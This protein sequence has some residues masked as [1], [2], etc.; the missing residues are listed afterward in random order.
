MP[1]VNDILEER[2]TTYGAFKD[3]ARVAQT[4]KRVCA[5]TPNW[6]LAEPDQQEA[7]DMFCSKMSRL[8]TGDINHLDSW[9]DIA[10]Y[11]TLVADRLEGKIR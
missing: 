6:K 1:E 8:L 10:G 7:L 9:Q 4:L 2:G 3:N 5:G 11:A